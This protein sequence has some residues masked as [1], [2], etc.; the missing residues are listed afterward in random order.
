MSSLLYLKG[1]MAKWPV[2]R[3]THRTT[4]KTH[5]T[6][7][8]QQTFRKTIVCVFRIN[9]YL[10][11]CGLYVYNN[12][13]CLDTCLKIAIMGTQWLIVLFKNLPEQLSCVTLN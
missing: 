12:Q 8:A 5:R 7:K 3:K 9:T 4:P 2:H 1:T 10:P 13:P 11:S 6:L